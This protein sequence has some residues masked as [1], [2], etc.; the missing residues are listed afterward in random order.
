MGDIELSLDTR[1][2]G[3]RKR[4]TKDFDDIR[5]DCRTDLHLHLSALPA[6]SPMIEWSELTTADQRG[7]NTARMPAGWR[8]HTHCLSSLSLLFF[9][10][11]SSS[12]STILSCWNRRCFSSRRLSSRPC[13]AP[14]WEGGREGAGPWQCIFC[15]V[16]LSLH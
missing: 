3:K 16:K 4:M 8:S 7:R 14:I 15:C 1:E 9:L 2:R 13:R 5:C 6:P 12:C 11:S 10:S